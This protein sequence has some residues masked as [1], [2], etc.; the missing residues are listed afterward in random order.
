MTGQGKL[1][2]LWDSRIEAWQHCNLPKEYHGSKQL[3]SAGKAMLERER[4]RVTDAGTERTGSSRYTGERPQRAVVN[5]NRREAA[6]R[7]ATEEL[8]RA[9]Q[10]TLWIALD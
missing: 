4:N 1:D 3:A 9:F 10:N 5:D 6:E 7:E 2:H 8:C